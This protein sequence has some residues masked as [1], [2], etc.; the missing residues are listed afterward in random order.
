[1][2]ETFKY[3]KFTSRT[4][5]IPADYRPLYK[6]GHVLLILHLSSRGG[7]ASLMKLHFLSWAI[8]SK[9]NIAIVKGWI[10]NNFKNDF[11]IWGIEPTV[12]RALVF[13]SADN[14]IK[15]DGGV[16]ALTERGTALV[17][18]IIKDKETFAD[19]K[20]FLEEIGKTEIT[21]GK[22]NDLSKQ[23]LINYA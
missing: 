6:I 13:A 12:N 11:H 5:P 1:M 7:K 21:E 4:I 16:F 2:N 18:S 20:A 17:K 10:K 3:I 19:E 15:D 22:I 8:K 23:L 14:L 9:K